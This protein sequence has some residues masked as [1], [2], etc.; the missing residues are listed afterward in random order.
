MEK[1][2]HYVQRGTAYVRYGY[3][4]VPALDYAKRT[5]KY[6]EITKQDAERERF[7]GKATVETWC[8]SDVDYNFKSDD[9]F[10]YTKEHELK[11]SDAIMGFEY[12]DLLPPQGRKQ[13]DLH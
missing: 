8:S 6:M 9:Y 11:E 7:E 1:Y 13:R 4:E 2:G 12:F 10:K 5:S 3:Y